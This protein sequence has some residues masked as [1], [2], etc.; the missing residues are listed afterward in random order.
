VAV[1]VVVV[2]DWRTQPRIHNFLTDDV[3]P[4]NNDNERQAIHLY[5]FLVVVFHRIVDWTIAT[6]TTAARAAWILP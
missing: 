5:I 6:V 3:V 4:H 2:V 1:V